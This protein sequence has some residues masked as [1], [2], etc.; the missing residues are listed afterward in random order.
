[1]LRSLFA[2]GSIAVIGA[3]SDSSKVG[4]V[5]LENLLKSGFS[6]DIFPVNPREDSILGVRCFRTVSDIPGSPD[7]AVICV[8]SDLVP[9]VVRECAG[10][11]IGF[12]III[13]GG[14]SETGEKGRKL[15]QEL[16]GIASETGIRIIGPNTV[17]VYFPEAKVNTTLTP[18]DRLWFPEPGTLSFISQSGA[19]GLLTMDT[20]GS[21]GIGIR[22]FVNLGNRTDLSESE[23]MEYLLEDPGTRS[24]AI[25]IESVKDGKA[26]LATLKRVSEVKPVVVLKSGTT[27]ESA[28][29]A[30]LHTGAMASDNAV[31]GG[32]LRQFGAVR[33]EN[34]TQLIDFARALA[35][36]PPMKGNRVAIVTTAGGVGVI[37]ADRIA[38]SRKGLVLA[39]FSTETRNKI[40]EAIVDIGSVENP[41]D[42]TAEGSVS[43]IDRVLKILS[44]S[45]EADAAIVYA[46]PQTPKMGMDVVD[47]VEKHFRGRMTI[48]VG[49][50]GSRLSDVLS[51]E[52]EKREIPCYSSTERVVSSLEALHTYG[53]WRQGGEIHES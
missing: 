1:M 15:E 50:V 21:R 13:S 34:E 16:L 11:S 6:G 18:A 24:I 26:F 47:A 44:E 41:I 3:S 45:G 5:V 42:L 27:P 32:V 9:G 36:S 35:C 46:L 39:T 31:F 43:A 23:L 30:A 2:P 4:H 8:R 29:A 22:H 53:S 38:S 28:R 33:A 10:K 48:V 51:R 17:G 25:Y 19:L 52:F 12:A 49:T 37:T 20:M 40:R 14:F 7:I